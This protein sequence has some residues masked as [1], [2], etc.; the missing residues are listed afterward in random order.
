MSRLAEAKGGRWV[1]NRP[2]LHGGREKARMAGRGKAWAARRYADARTLRALRADGRADPAARGCAGHRA[3]GWAVR[4]ARRHAGTRAGSLAAR[5][6]RGGQSAARRH[7]GAPGTRALRAGS[8]PPLPPNLPA[9][10]RYP[11]ARLAPRRR[12]PGACPATPDIPQRAPG[13]P[14]RTQL[15]SEYRG[16]S[17]S[18]ARTHPSKRARLPGARLASTHGGRPTPD[19]SGSQQTPS[20]RMPSHPRR[21]SARPAPRRALSFPASTPGVR[22]TPQR[23]PQGAS[24]THPAQRAPASPMRTWRAPAPRLS[25]HSRHGLRSL[26]PSGTRFWPFLPCF[27]SKRDPA[28]RKT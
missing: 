23:A 10:P 20:G 14:T 4:P 24:S 22:P 3:R 11:P 18:P 15:P 8:L 13:S 12:P 25:G 28:M 7:A 21:P 27:T 26:G 16:A 1:Q 5:G 19:A 2:N 9:R 17:D 6:R